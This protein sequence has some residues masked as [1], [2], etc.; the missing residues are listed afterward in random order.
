MSY[1]CI[2][3]G[4]IYLFLYKNKKFDV[5]SNNRKLYIVKNIGKSIGLF[6]LSFMAFNTLYQG[7]LYDKWNNK[8]IHKLGFMYASSDILSLM[9]VRKLPKS[10]KIH[11]TSVL[12]LS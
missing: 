6:I 7:V 8:D 9:I 5:L 2:I 10:T 4:I 1:Y 12:F 3:Y 11:H